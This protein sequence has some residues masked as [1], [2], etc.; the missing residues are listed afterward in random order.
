MPAEISGRGDSTPSIPLKTNNRLLAP[1]RNAFDGDA[2]T[3]SARVSAE[4]PNLSR[5]GQIS[6]QSA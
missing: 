4:Q 3:D 5:N 1:C 6:D 2:A